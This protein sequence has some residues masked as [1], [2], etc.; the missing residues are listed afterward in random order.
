MNL[1]AN[2]EN[3]TTGISY[4]NSRRSH[5]ISLLEMTDGLR[6]VNNRLGMRIRPTA[7]ALVRGWWLRVRARGERSE[8]ITRM[9]PEGFV[10][11]IGYCNF[12]FS[13]PPSPAVSPG[14][15]FWSVWWSVSW[16]ETSTLKVEEEVL[17]FERTDAVILCRC[18]RGGANFSFRFCC[19]RQSIGEVFYPLMHSGWVDI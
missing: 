17:L 8:F 15:R 6:W 5:F 11:T 7:A 2:N 19:K 12:I 1:L 10:V 3:S 9:P 18:P 14:G 16:T 4:L 13:R